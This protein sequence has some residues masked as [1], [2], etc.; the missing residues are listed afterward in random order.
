[1]TSIL[2]ADFVKSDF[3]AV[4]DLRVIINTT[5][6]DILPSLVHQFYVFRYFIGYILTKV[7]L[8]VV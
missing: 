6:C 4:Y 7:P 5:G 2:F 8:I 3:T 1:M